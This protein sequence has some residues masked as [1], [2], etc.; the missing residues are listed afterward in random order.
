M[1]AWAIDFLTVADHIDG[2]PKGDLVYTSTSPDKEYTAYFYRDSGGATTGFAM[3]GILKKNDTTETKRV[4]WDYPRET[5][6]VEWEESTIIINKIRLK[7]W[8]E[9]YDYR[10]GVY[11]E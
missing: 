9:I 4:Y 5:V 3:L 7:L 10:I 8:T 2:V 11:I 1:W 6:K